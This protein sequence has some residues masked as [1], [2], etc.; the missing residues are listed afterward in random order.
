MEILWRRLCFRG[1]SGEKKIR[2]HHAQLQQDTHTGQ[3]HKC[4]SAIPLNSKWI[5]AHSRFSNFSKLVLILITLANAQPELKSNY[6]PFMSGSFFK[7]LTYK[8]EKKKKERNSPN[9]KRG[10]AKQIQEPKRVIEAASRRLIQFLCG[11]LLQHMPKQF[12]TT[13]GT[14]ASW[15]CDDGR[16][17]WVRSFLEEKLWGNE[18]LAAIS[19][20]GGVYF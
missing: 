5:Q 3:K 13:C 15:V 8:K 4:K 2:S 9:Q 10:S 18:D 7:T 1:P 6:S 16:V 17:G 14:R 20:C 11:P 19:M 12:L